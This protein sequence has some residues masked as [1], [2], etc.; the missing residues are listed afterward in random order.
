M[1]NVPT[2]RIRNI[3]LLSHSGAGKTILAEAMLHTA[4]VTT[5]LGTVEDGTTC[6]GL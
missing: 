3:V 1:A 2:E 5:R 4:G 6:V